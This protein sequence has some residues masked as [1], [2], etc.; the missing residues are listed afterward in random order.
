MKTFKDQH[1]FKGVQKL[2]VD[3]LPAPSGP[4]HFHPK[5][6]PCPA[7]FRGK[8]LLGRV[9][10]LIDGGQILHCQGQSTSAI[11]SLAWIW[12]SACKADQLDFWTWIIFSVI[13]SIIL[14]KNQPGFSFFVIIPSQSVF[15]QKVVGLKSQEGSPSLKRYHP[16]A[17]WGVNGTALQVTSFSFIVKPQTL[18]MLCP[19]SFKCDV[20]K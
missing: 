10:P 6:H 12:G 14:F 11:M 16:R 19:L 5:L 18:V 17:F 20:I 15:D 8:P 4:T 2:V 9:T 7:A 1:V 13:P 3:P